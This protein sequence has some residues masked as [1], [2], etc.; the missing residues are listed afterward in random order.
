MEHSSEF[1]PYRDSPTHAVDYELQDYYDDRGIPVSLWM[2]GPGRDLVRLV[3][4]SHEL[5]MD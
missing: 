3:T 1:Q 5:P 4:G 2:K